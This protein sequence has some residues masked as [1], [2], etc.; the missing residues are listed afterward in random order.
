MS[1]DNKEIALDLQA[2]ISRVEREPGSAIRNCIL[3]LL[4][5]ALNLLASS[6]AS[7]AIGEAIRSNLD[8][9]IR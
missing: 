7:E 1:A 6:P 2:V 3:F 4:Y 9:L 8:F 5:A